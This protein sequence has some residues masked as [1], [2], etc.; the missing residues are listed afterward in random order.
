MLDKYKYFVVCDYREKFSSFFDDGI[1]Y[2]DHYKKSNVDDIVNV[3]CRLGFSCEYFGGVNELIEAI[4]S[5]QKFPNSVFLNFNDGLTQIHKRG[6]T[7]MLL[8]L[9][10][11]MY[12]GSDAFAS[13]LVSDKFYTN[14]YLKSFEDITV[15]NS[16][17]YDIDDSL[18]KRLNIQFPIIVKPNNEGSS[19]GI[20]SK[21]FCSNIEE[22][23]AQIKRLDGKFDKLLLEE[24]V[25]GMEF[26]VFLLG[27]DE[28]PVCQPLAIGLDDKYIFEKEIFDADVKRKH[29]RTYKAPESFLSPSKIEE[30]KTLSQKIFK[31]LN[32]RDYARLDFRYRNESFYLLEVNTVPAIGRGSDAGEVCKVMNISFEEFI[33]ILISTVNQRLSNHI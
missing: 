33:K 29:L 6:Q 12:S 32:L 8:E 30:L 9:I 11:E 10:T 14:R 17:L 18:P 3:L 5:N 20:D 13:L 28:F 21:S 2:N 23:Q 26:T 1:V 31:L 7:P 25:S 16:I 24:Y 27:N 15:P 19:I 4:N 22:L